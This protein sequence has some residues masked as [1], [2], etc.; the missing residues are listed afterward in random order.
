M[1]R[2]YDLRGQVNDD[3]LNEHTVDIIARAYGTML[4]KR[5]IDTAVIGYDYRKSSQMVTRVATEA[6]LSTGID[7]IN[8]GM[9]LTPMMY[10]AQYH[11]DSKGGVMVTAS[12]NPVGWSGFKFALGYSQTLGPK[13]MQ[14]LYDLTVSEEFATGSG[15]LREEDFLD[16]YI[17]D[18]VERVDIARTVRVVINTGNGTPGP[19]ATK[20]LDAAGCE[21]VGLHTEL[22]WDFPH[23]YPNPALVDMME[24]TGQ[25]TIESGAEIG[26][27]FDGDG[28]RLGTT[29]EKGENVWPDRYLILLA[30]QVLENNPGAKIIFD[31]KCS[32]TLPED[33]EAHGGVPIMWKTGHSYIKQKLW[34]EN[35]PL[36]GEM[37]GHI[38]FGEPEYHGFDDAVFAALKLAEY[39]SQR[40]R[41]MSALIED[42]PYYVSTPTLQVKCPV[43]TEQYEESVKYNVVDQITEE[44]K[45]EGYD[46][47]DINGARVTF[48]DGWALVRASSNLPVLV[49]RFE[50]KTE[51][52]VE[53]LK[54]LVR[55]KLSKY[56]EVG[57]EWES[58]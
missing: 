56:P 31:V 22:D 3:Q 42:T 28:D 21:V 7:V 29:N 10:L 24:E 34:E 33:I 9:V 40:D 17:A 14:E 26:F 47:I 49:M 57:T 18:V 44:F 41:P 54:V 12:H 1:F 36:A 46:V 30:R 23:Y 45:T 25:K 55:D 52:R 4:R 43:D 11:F 8:L 13:E 20:A 15:D 58:G 32:Q 19:I 51:E 50:A 2:E 37:S 16:A 48:D 5:D 39:L 27:A 38:F 53:E 6:L 35:A